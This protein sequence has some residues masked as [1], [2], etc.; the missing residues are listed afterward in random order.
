M[1]V[2]SA[3]TSSV[4]LALAAILLLHQ[5]LLNVCHRC[6]GE[7][8]SNASINLVA[9]LELGMG[10]LMVFGVGRL[11]IHH[12]TSLG[13]QIDP[14]WWRR[15]EAWVASE[16]LRRGADNS[17]SDAALPWWARTRPARA[18][19]SRKHWN[20]SL[21][22]LT[23]WQCGQVFSGRAAPLRFR[24]LG[25][26]GPLGRTLQGGGVILFTHLRRTSGSV[27]EDCILLPSL[28][29]IVGLRMNRPLRAG[30]FTGNAVGI[31]CYEGGLG[32]FGS[33]SLPR[34]ELVQLQQRLAHPLLVYRHC[35]HGLHAHLL[36]QRPHAY[37]TFLREPAQ[38]LISWARLCLGLRSR[39]LGREGESLG[40]EMASLR[41][42][43]TPRPGSNC[44][45]VL[46]SGG[47]VAVAVET[48]F[49]T[50]RD[51]AL[52]Q[53][54]RRLP[55]ASLLQQESATP[56]GSIPSRLELLLDDNYAVRMLCGGAVHE[57]ERPVGLAGRDCALR[58]LQRYALVG[59]VEEQ[60]ASVCLLMRSLGLRPQGALD[61]REI[62]AYPVAPDFELAHGSKYAM[63]LALHEAAGRHL[64]RQLRDSPECAQLR[65]GVAPPGT[66]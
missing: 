37:L 34:R 23:L 22:P 54:P 20:G 15:W 6:M 39:C 27:L 28:A 32:R 40:G 24:G 64:A 8:A 14:N 3:S 57:Q 50:A 55:A 63:D 7:S 10:V 49:Y 29:A 26:V 11:E 65:V 1:L 2:A 18:N 36:P 66:R 58:S 45:L 21:K 5:C 53:L 52:E 42:I 60:A 46:A 38:R 13:E 48:A 61:A 17:S 62:H 59:L 30:R 41:G 19:R 44:S 43:C 35:P 16:Q 4:F 9:G 56:G 12:Y 33:P 25:A 31:N 47:H 51:R